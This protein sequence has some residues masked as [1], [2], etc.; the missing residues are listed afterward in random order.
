MSSRS[1]RVPWILRP[2]RPMAVRFL[3]QTARGPMV[4]ALPAD[5]G[6]VRPATR[7]QSR[8]FRRV[9]RAVGRFLQPRRKVAIQ[10]WIINS[11]RIPVDWQPR[12]RLQACFEEQLTWLISRSESRE[13]AG[14][15]LEFGVYQGN[16]LVCMDRALD[17]LNVGG[18]R[19]FGFDS[20]EGLPASAEFDQ[21]WSQGQFRSDLEFTRQLLDDAGVDWDRIELVK[22]FYD[23]VLNEPL[24]AQLG[25]DVASMVMIDCD[26]YS[27]TRD[28]LAFCGPRLA[29]DAVIL[30]DDWESTDE[31][32]GEKLAFREFLEANPHFRA[33]PQGG[34]HQ[35]AEVFRLQRI[36]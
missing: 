28:A 4:E 2:L 5:S 20:F 24:A 36:G 15:Y 1:P 30:F 25:L 35:K 10:E 29:D 32:H 3:R 33:E 14:D 26:L 12:E 31:E 17:A 34:Y 27:S 8:L 18:M 23:E 9:G 6:T 22:G 21:I 13:P 7:L 19:L 16:S 11:F